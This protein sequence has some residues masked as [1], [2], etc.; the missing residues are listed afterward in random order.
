HEPNI[1]ACHSISAYAKHCAELGICLDWR[2]DELCPKNCFGGQEYYSCASGCVRTCENYEELDNNPKACPISFIDGCFCPDGMVLHE[3]S[4]M[5]SSHCKLCD[6]EGHRV[7][8][9]WQTDACTMCECLERGINCN[10]KACPR[11]PHCDKGYI[12]VEV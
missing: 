6:D 2:S 3:G 5:D 11:D 1:S 4:C 12:L 10:T 8:E 9:S 7:G